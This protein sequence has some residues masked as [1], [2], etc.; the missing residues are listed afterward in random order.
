MSANTGRAPAIMIASAEYA[1]ESGDVMT[2]SPGPMPSARRE[3]ASASVPA[4]TPIAA[5]AWQASA[6]SFSKASSSGPRTNQP[7]ASTRS[8]AARTAPLS[9][10][11]VSCRNGISA[12]RKASGSRVISWVWRQGIGGRDARRA[13]SEV[14]LSDHQCNPQSGHIHSR[15]EQ[16]TEVEELRFAVDPMVMMNGHF[17]DR[18]LRVLDLLHHLQADHAAASFERHPVE[19]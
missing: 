2:S 7:R 10:P 6:N 5:G 19:N 18:E 17:R 13:R 12:I 3:I 9:S 11:G 8:M 16:P 14:F 4:P 15:L 1:A